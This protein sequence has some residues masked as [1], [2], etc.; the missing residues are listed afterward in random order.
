[1]IGPLCVRPPDGQ[2]GDSPLE[3]TRRCTADP[4]SL[5]DTDGPEWL[6][7]LRPPPSH[8]G[9]N[10]CPA[11]FVRGPPLATVPR[12]LRHDVSFKERTGPHAQAVIDFVH[13][14]LLFSFP[15]V[16]RRGQSLQ[17]SQSIDPIPDQSCPPRLLCIPCDS[18]CE[19]FSHHHA[20]SLADAVA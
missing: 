17:G 12:Q 14:S 6:R 2:F 13:F 19:S 18:A 15:S 16:N 9:S 4:D 20:F 1:M 10:V 11:N 7:S 3:K 5:P 8:P